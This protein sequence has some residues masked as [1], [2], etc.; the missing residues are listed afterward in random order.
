MNPPPPAE[1]LA[2]R[3]FLGPA[4]RT[5][6]DRRLVTLVRDGYETAFEEIVRRYGKSLGRYA[7][8]IVGGRSEEVTQDAFSKALLALRRESEAEIELR[9]WLYRIVRN[10]ALNDLRDRPPDTTE[11]AEALGGG[12]RSAAE[13]FERREELSELLERLRSLPEPQRAAIVMRELE[14]LGHEEIATALGMS[15]GA[16]RQAIYRA[17]QAL[18][19]GLGMMI[20]LPLLR[21]LFDHGVE[22]GAA[23]GAGGAVAAGSAMGGAGAGTALKVGVVT[24]VLAGGVGT[25][26]ALKDRAPERG[27]E[28]AAAAVHGGTG[29]AESHP[30]SAAARS[31]AAMPGGGAGATGGEGTGGGE[32]EHG[33]QG[34]LGRGGESGGSSGRG[35]SGSGDEGGRGP[36]PSQGAG[37]GHS[38]LGSGSDDGPGGGGS[39]SGGSGTSGG[40][41]GPSGGGSGPSGDGGASGSGDGGLDGSGGGHDSGAELPPPPT[42]SGDGSAGSGDGSG[43]GDLRSGSGGDG[44]GSDDPVI[45]GSVSG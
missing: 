3:L 36:G 27:V 25:G 40:G 45:F 43:S 29:S 1:G 21:S 39:R 17:R 13:E 44:S 28:M 15:G 16:A 9:P 20:P 24:A 2:S 35:T 22:A 18:R 12:S 30:A 19:D 34:D 32:K 4:L 37:P 31:A 42:T 23:A 5:Q 26:L 10:T 41:P 6:P 33:L 11:L 38:G 14:G 7:A 8:A